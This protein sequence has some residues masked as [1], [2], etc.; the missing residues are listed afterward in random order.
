ME[1]L[2]IIFMKKNIVY[3]VP[4]GKLLRLE[5]DLED[6]VIKKIEISG[7]FFVHPEEGLLEIEKSLLG[8]DMGE[9]AEV[10]R[11]VLKEKNI[12]LIGFS[13]EDL[14]EALER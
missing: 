10:V 1:L 7:D 14:K 2:E 8:V 4:K 12:E 3:K 11:R 6:T 13:P 9:V 5:L